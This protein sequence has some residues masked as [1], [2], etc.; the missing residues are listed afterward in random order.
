M[1]EKIIDIFELISNKFSRP[2]QIF[3]CRQ[4]NL[5]RMF[6]ESLSNFQYYSYYSYPAWKTEKID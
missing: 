6:A 3:L 2:S 1:A 4:Q 5:S